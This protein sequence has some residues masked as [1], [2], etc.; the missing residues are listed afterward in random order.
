MAAKLQAMGYQA[1]FYEPAAGGHTLG[2]DND[3]QATHM[4]LA[5][6]FLRRAIGWGLD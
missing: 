5:Y 1:H 4:S 2:K 6:G 3:E